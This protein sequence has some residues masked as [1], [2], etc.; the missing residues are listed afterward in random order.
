[1][2]ESRAKLHDINQSVLRSWSYGLR[3]ATRL[4]STPLYRRQLRINH[5]YYRL[6]RLLANHL[7]SA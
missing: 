7:Q 4:L 5:N 6:F 2:S 1:M 3:S